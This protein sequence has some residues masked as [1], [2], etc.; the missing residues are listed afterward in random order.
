[1]LGKHWAGPNLGLT[2]VPEEGWHYTE[3]DTRGDR[4]IPK[5]ASPFSKAVRAQGGLLKPRPQ[6]QEAAEKVPETKAQDH[7][8]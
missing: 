6:R 8:H 1:M 7:T 3:K 4:G 5:G 2:F